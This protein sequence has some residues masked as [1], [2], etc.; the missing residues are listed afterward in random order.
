MKKDYRKQ[1]IV[2]MPDDLN[3]TIKANYQKWG[4]NNINEFIC[5]AIDK[6]INSHFNTVSQNNDFLIDDFSSPNKNLFELVEKLTLLNKIIEQKS[7]SEE[8]ITKYQSILVGFN[9]IMI[10]EILKTIPNSD[11]RFDEI[12][13]FIYSEFAHAEKEEFTEIINNIFDEL[14]NDE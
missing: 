6:S 13:S 8:L 11:G 14:K 2:R 9:S 10:T 4:Y 12:K 3:L 1:V 7:K 5:S